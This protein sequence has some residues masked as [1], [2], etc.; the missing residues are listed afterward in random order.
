[1]ALLGGLQGIGIAFH[2]HV[3]QQLF[4]GGIHLFAGRRLRLRF[5]AHA[6]VFADS[7]VT[8]SGDVDIFHV[9]HVFL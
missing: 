5:E 1:M 3:R 7:D 2:D 4:T 8:H 9:F 6:D